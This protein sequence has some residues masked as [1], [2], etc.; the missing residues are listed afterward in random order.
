MNIT[1]VGG[2][3]VT[4]HTARLHAARGDVVHV[5]SPRPCDVPG[6]W[7]IG[8]AVSGR[9]VRR[10][11]RGADVV[12]W[13]ASTQ[14]DIEEFY[15][16]GT[17]N[18]ANAARQE[19]ARLVLCG[20]RG[21]HQGSRSRSLRAWSS[22]S[23]DCH[24]IVPELTELRLPAL[25]ARDGHLGGPW[26]EA[27]AAGRAIRVADPGARLAPLWA[28]DA[29]R[30]VSSAIRGELAVGIYSVRGPEEVVMGQLAELVASAAGGRV[31]V[32]PP[33][34]RRAEDLARLDDQ[35][36]EHD[37][38]NALGCGDRKTLSQWL[39]DVLGPTTPN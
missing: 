25:F 20:P 12:V 1:F 18:T 23:E 19:G 4:R 30:A 28:G 11:M 13:T 15:A 14:D 8:D 16:L 36:A 22:A 26:L 10:A 3:V 37:D 17:R 24:E 31:G 5:V 32:I 27:V 33:F 39:E 21:A 9:G 29:A 6:L 38:W 35:L 7:T 2:G 34:S